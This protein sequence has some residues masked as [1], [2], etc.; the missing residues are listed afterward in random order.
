MDTLC[1]D[2]YLHIAMHLPGCSVSKLCRTSHD[3]SQVVRKNPAIWTGLIHCLPSK[4]EESE[5]AENADAVTPTT[6]CSS[7]LNT[8]HMLTYHNA[9]ATCRSAVRSLRA[10]LTDHYTLIQDA[11]ASFM[12]YFSRDQ[13]DHVPVFPPVVDAQDSWAD[14]QSKMGTI[15]L[16]SRWDAVAFFQSVLPSTMLLR[17]ILIAV[18][19]HPVITV[20]ACSRRTQSCE[21][22]Y[23]N[24]RRELKRITRRFKHICRSG[25]RAAHMLRA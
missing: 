6:C 15:P 10:E 7:P 12:A 3:W 8:R 4:N 2:T 11:V 19:N 21:G 23:A 24:A 5:L 18:A 22:K 13:E 1:Q 17:N 20:M 16:C 14:F 9:Y 25:M